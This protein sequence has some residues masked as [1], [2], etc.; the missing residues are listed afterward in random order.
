MVANGQAGRYAFLAAL[1][2]HDQRDLRAAGAVRRYR[3]GA[4]LLFE[5]EPSRLVLVLLEGRAKIL[6][7]SENGRQQMLGIAGPGELLG[8]LAAIDGVP[9]SASA[10]AA[11]PV[12]AL[13]LRPSEFRDFLAS[14]A[15]ASY[16]LLESVVHRVRANDRKRLEHG[17]YSVGARVA[18]QLLDL[19][20]G[21]PGGGGEAGTTALPLT[22]D[23]LAALVGASREQVVR[24]LRSLR[25]DGVL[26]TGRR[27]LTILDLDRLRR[28]AL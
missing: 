4:T 11:E 1:D 8:E 20:D 17:A 10:V 28:R 16:R 14:H 3:T 25:D 21:I 26:R 7:I 27:S 12:T 9:H 24:S 19:S 13:A 5:G 15:A 23:D 18:R 22:Q 2:E 6:S